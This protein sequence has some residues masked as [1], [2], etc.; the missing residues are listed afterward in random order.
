MEIKNGAIA[1]TITS[2][3]ETCFAEHLDEDVDLVLIEMAI[4]DQRVEFLAWS[5]EN[6]V[7]AVLELP[8][9]PAVMHLQV[10]F[11]TSALSGNDKAYSDPSTYVR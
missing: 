1:G 3:Y 9:K 6:L 11:V 4:N 8:N 10:C 5:Y 2:Y 7:R